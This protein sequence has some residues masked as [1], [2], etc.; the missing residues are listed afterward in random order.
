MEKMKKNS[1]I[2]ID[3]DEHAA[4]NLK[5]T[6]PWEEQGFIFSG[7]YPQPLACPICAVPDPLLVIS[8]IEFPDLL[9]QD[10]FKALRSR[11]P[12][13]FL[14]ILTKD[15]R[16]EPVREAFKY[17]VFRYLIKPFNLGEVIELLSVSDNV[18]RKGNSSSFV[19]GE[20][21]IRE[22]GI[23]GRVQAYVEGHYTDPDLTLKSI[24]EEFH[25]NYSYL[26]FLFKKQTGLT[27]SDYIS[28]L[29]IRFVKELL[30]DTG[31]KM[32]QIAQAAGFTDSQVL[33]Y[34]FKNAAGMTPR[35]Y[36]E[37]LVSDSVHLSG[38]DTGN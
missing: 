3:S 17:G 16:L 21:V 15:E 13:A 1:V 20:V 9:F 11:F 35:A 32:S 36:R 8:E 31:M 30:R 6:V 10:A 12:Q 38:D 22:A 4:L 14:V 5:A 18:I 25:L 19:S 28:G 7:V 27:Y 34:A 37:G 26:S 29:R 23:A 33:Y 24:A 2:L